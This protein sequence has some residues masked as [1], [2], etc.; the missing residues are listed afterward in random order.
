MK[1]PIQKSI[2]VNV[3]VVTFQKA[4]VADGFISI[5]VRNALPMVLAEAGVQVVQLVV[6][7]EVLVVVAVLV[8]RPPCRFHPDVRLMHHA[9]PVVQAAE[10][11][12]YLN[13]N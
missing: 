8:H 5:R 11:N 7:V 12:N 10:I 4:A 1:P 9:V 13:K 6:T 3:P 2:R